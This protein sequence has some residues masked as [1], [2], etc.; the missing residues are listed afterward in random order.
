MSEKKNSVRQTATKP[1][2]SAETVS[3]SGKSFPAIRFTSPDRTGENLTSQF[4]SVPKRNTRAASETPS[5]AKQ[6]NTGMPNDLK[7]GIESMSGYSMDDV[8]VHYNSAQPAQLQALAY[9]QG[10]DIH[11]APGQEKHLPHEAWHVV[12]QKQGR[13]K[14]TLQMKEAVPVNDDV[15]LE[16]EADTM[17]AKALIQGRTI[18]KMEAI[19]SATN[20]I[21]VKEE[22]AQR[23]TIQRSVESEAE[24]QQQNAPMINMITNASGVLATIPWS[25]LA[26]GTDSIGSGATV[27][28]IVGSLTGLGGTAANKIKG[29]DKPDLAGAAGDIS[30]GIGASITSLVKS[31]FAIKAIYN[32]AKGKEKELVGAG[33]IATSILSALKSG[34][35]AAASIQKYVTGSVPASIVSVIP[36]LG[37]A[38]AACDIIK[39]AYIT[40]NA[41]SSKAEMDAVSDSFRQGLADLVGDPEITVPTLFANE[42]RGKFGN[43]ATYLRLKPGLLDSLNSLLDTGLPESTRRNMAVN[44]K[45]IHKIPADVSIPALISAIKYYELGSKMQ[46]INQKRTVQGARS[47]FLNIMSLAGEIAKFFP[48]DGGA[49]AGVLLGTSAGVGAALSASKFIQGMARN[50]SVLGGDSNRSAGAKHKEYVNHTRTIYEF[51]S[52]INQPVTE[53]EKPKVMRGQQILSATGV[54]MGTVLKTDYNNSESVTKQVNLIVNAMKAGR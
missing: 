31:V 47:I 29:E 23:Q 54:N 43:R 17:G 34:F 32:T 13:V 14:P 16:N 21:A 35:E 9:A 20:T 48:A 18:Q 1:R 24:F 39:N 10:T 50:H 26:A 49:T 2:S 19:Q 4:K 25:T 36:G 7:S 44:F 46:E 41:H 38:I 22:V 15:G 33:E 42:K 37:V 8:K 45:R 27:T 53:I 12:Q 51:L 28:G 40:Y 6:N 5:L 30:L 3:G 11:I 52:N